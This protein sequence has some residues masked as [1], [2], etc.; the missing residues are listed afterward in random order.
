[1]ATSPAAVVLVVDD[2]RNMLSLMAKVLRGVANVLTADRGDT[3]M[4]VLARE[5]VDVVLCDLRMP[6]VDGLAVFRECK[7]L[8]P[9]A[10]FILM[11]AH[12]TVDTAVSTLKN[13]A[14]DYLTKPF[15]PE[16]ARDIVQRALYSG[17]PRPEI[18]KEDEILPGV[19]G[20]SRT[21]R[22]F[23]NVVQTL[24]ATEKRVILVGEPGVGKRRVAQAIHRLSDHNQGPFVSANARTMSSEALEAGLVAEHVH[25]TGPA[26]GLPPLLAQSMDGT[27]LLEEIDALPESIQARLCSV[28]ERTV[29]VHDEASG[30][31]RPPIRVLA[32]CQ[33]QSVEAVRRVL[34][35]DLWHRLGTAVITIPPLRCRDEDIPVLSARILAQCRASC[36]GSPTVGFTATAMEALVAFDWP[37]N[38]GQLE[39]AI[40]QAY[41]VAAGGLVSVEHLPPEVRATEPGH[42]SW[43]TMTWAEALARGRAEAAHRY[44][45]AVL[46]RFDGDVVK[47]A[48]VADVERESFYR[49][50]RRY[51]IQPEGLRRA[52]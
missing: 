23:A 5:T 22:E 35:E 38:V 12:A 24:A 49:L 26:G 11:T 25:E 47:A 52:P 40:E 33:I 17:P 37:G 10:K 41:T 21:M 4:A 14:Y 45:V 19:H 51:G 6:D 9:R 50:L 48:A 28:L 31:P 1:M 27:L 46:R 29:P 44:L 32:T 20:R 43:D 36:S 34:R 42:S 2:K 8:Q 13:G 18:E 15:D 3:A 16:L 7:R 39:S 30:S